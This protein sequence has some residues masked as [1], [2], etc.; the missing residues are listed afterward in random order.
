MAADGDREEEAQAQISRMFERAQ[1]PPSPATS[2]RAHREA[3]AKA[4]GY[5]V[6]TWRPPRIGAAA[7]AGGRADPTVEMAEKIFSSCPVRPRG[8]HAVFGGCSST[9]QAR[10]AVAGIGGFVMGGMFG[11]FMAGLS[12]DVPGQPLPGTVRASPPSPL[13]SHHRINTV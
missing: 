8:V 7:V 13:Y 6:H 10:G 2:P 11:L 5:T 4:E 1:S 3:A 9:R 12:A